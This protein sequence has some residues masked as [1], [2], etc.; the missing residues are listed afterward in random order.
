LNH[1]K[2]SRQKAHDVLRAHW[3]AGAPQGAQNLMAN[4][5]QKAVSAG[6]EGVMPVGVP[7]GGGTNSVG[8]M[9]S[10]IEHDGGDGVL[11][12]AGAIGKDLQDN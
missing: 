12:V 9:M 10:G 4:K 7:V 2:T 1:L 3:H 6:G 5:R 8:G 11:A